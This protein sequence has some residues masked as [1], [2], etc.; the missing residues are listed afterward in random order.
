MLDLVSQNGTFVN[1]KEI[2]SQ[3][4]KEGDV[5]ELGETIIV[6]AG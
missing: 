6:F 4:L 5:I 1:G 3:L 2:E